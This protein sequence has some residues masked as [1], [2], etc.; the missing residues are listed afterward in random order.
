MRRYASDTF[1]PVT[2]LVV[3]F[4]SQ[5]EVA[6]YAYAMVRRIEP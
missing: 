3:P 2:L 1:S 5:L 4:G 6:A